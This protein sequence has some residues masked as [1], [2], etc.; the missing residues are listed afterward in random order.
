MPSEKECVLRERA[1]CEHGMIVV[2][3]GRNR[4]LGGAW[5]GT[6]PYVEAKY[7]LPTVTR[8]RVVKDEFGT[9]WRVGADGDLRHQSAGC[10]GSAPVRVTMNRVTLWADL[11]ANPTEEVGDT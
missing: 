1:A 7:P 2:F 4:D 3:H 8:P 10:W 6:R 9:P 5:L 11:L